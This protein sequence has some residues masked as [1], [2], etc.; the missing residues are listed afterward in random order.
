MN[1]VSENNKNKAISF[2]CNIKAVEH[3]MLHR[4]A[5]QLLNAPKN[6]EQHTTTVLVISF[7]EYFIYDY[8]QQEY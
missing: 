1:N 5:Q 6:R 3:A 7:V 2:K 4:T 8:L